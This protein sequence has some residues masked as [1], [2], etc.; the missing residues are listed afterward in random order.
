[1][2]CTWTQAKAALNDPDGN[3]AIIYTLA[4][5]KGRDNIWVGAVDGLRYNNSIFDF[6]LLGVF[7]RR[8]G[9]GGEHHNC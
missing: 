5:G 6:E 4:V 9:G 7:E 8:C 2:N 1:M 3:P